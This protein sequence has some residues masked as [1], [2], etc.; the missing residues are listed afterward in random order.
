MLGPLIETLDPRQMKKT[1]RCLQVGQPGDP[2]IGLTLMLEEFI[3]NGRVQEGHPQE[4][5]QAKDRVNGEG[6]DAAA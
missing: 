6:E 3:A 5:A 1:D 4:K 2:Q